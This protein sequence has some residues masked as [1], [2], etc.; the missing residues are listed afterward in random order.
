MEAPG[1]HGIERRALPAVGSAERL[2][3]ALMLFQALTACAVAVNEEMRVT[4]DGLQRL[5]REW[6]AAATRLQDLDTP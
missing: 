3:L 1:T 6:E 2:A 5:H 4:V